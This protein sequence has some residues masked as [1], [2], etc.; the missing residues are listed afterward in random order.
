V[1]FSKVTR[2]N[3]GNTLVTQFPFSGLTKSKIADLF[4]SYRVSLGSNDSQRFK[5]IRQF[6]SIQ[7]DNFSKI[8][9]QILMKT[10]EDT[11]GMTTI[12]LVDIIEGQ[13]SPL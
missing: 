10:K 3:T 6:R 5:I 11:F 13:L 1:G 7:R 12:T 2:L 4:R 8:I 9:D